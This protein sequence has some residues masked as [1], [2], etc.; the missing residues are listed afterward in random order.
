MLQAIIK[1]GKVRAEEIPTPLV[2]DGSLLIK[3]VN[4]CISAGTEIS[5]VKATEKSVI[6]KALEKPEHIIKFLKWIQNEGLEN[7]IERA[8]G[9]NNASQ[10]TGYSISGIVI[11]IGKGVTGFRVGDKVAA[12][13]A[14]IANHAEFVDVPQNLVMNM[15]KDMGFMEASS[16]TLGGIAIQGVRRADLKLGEYCVVIGAGILGLLSIQML[17]NSGIR[18][19]AID[20]DEKRLEIAKELGCEIAIN[21]TQE[22]FIK[23]INNWTCGH[24]TDAVLFTAATSSSEPLSQAFQ[25]CR[26]KGKVVL[27]GVVGMEIKR[28]DIYA[29][30]LDFIISTSYGPGRYDRNYEEKGLD[31]PY[32]YVRW[33]ENRNMEE[34]LRLVHNGA[35]KLDKIINAVYPINNVTDAFESLQNHKDKPLMVILDYGRFEEKQLEQ[36]LNHDKKVFINTNPINKDTINIG[37]VGTGGFAT[38]MHLPNIKKLNDKF[39]LYAVMN[40]TGH[41][42]KSVA[43]QYGANY[44][45]T[46]YNDILNDENIDLIMI[47]TRH[48]SHASFVLKALKAGKNVFVEKPLAVNQEE[49][50]EIKKY[51]SD[52]TITNK[53]ILMVGFNRRFSKYAQEIK[54][55]TDRRINPLF[56]HYRMNAGFIPFNSWIHEDGGRII[57]EACHIIDLMTFLTGSKVESINYESLTPNNGKFSDSDNKS[58]ILKYQD[59]SICTIEY[60]AVGSKDFPKEYMEVHFDE[61]TIVM[62]DYKSLK[63][64]GIKTKDISTE[65]SEK[66]Q[67]EELEYLYTALKEPNETWPIDFW[68]MIQTTEITFG[69][70]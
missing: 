11:A 13:G 41:K 47:C 36:Y 25:I 43:S 42:A 70:E 32:P 21:P 56:I 37:L 57:G 1:R 20:L 66:G 61:K 39:K 22:D 34:Y 54:K 46:D 4:S 58:I 64:F 29:K 53:P 15:P 38:G 35:I 2:S 40:R 31:Y 17:K 10:P 49:L 3:V 28:E 6:K 55:H 48:D 14:G 63:G 18:V 44:A 62:D 50:N 30:E 9:I 7:A 68:D 59:G 19:A 12:A 45:T 5:G 65:T 51:Y 8:K 69:I 16:V 60:F 33:T 26:K 23:T 52:D 67:L 27:V 24:G